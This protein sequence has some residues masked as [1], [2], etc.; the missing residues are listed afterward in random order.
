MK[1]NI[2]LL[3]ILI[4]LLTLTYFVHERGEE[5]QRRAYLERHQLFNPERLGSIVSFSN[6]NATVLKREGTYYVRDL[7]LEV[8]E[9]KMNE[10]FALLVPIQAKRFLED[11]ELEQMNL[12]IA[13]PHEHYTLTFTFENGRVEY[14]IGEKLK[15]GQDFYLRLRWQEGDR[16]EV[17]QYLIATD[18]SPSEGIYS[19]E[20]YHLSDRKYMRLLSLVFL[21][22]DFFVST[23]LIPDLKNT[24]VNSVSFDNR[25]NR[26]FRL[27]LAPELGIEP[28]PLAGV[29]VDWELVSAWLEDVKRLNAEKYLANYKVEDLPRRLALITLSLQNGEDV[30]LKLYRDPHDPLKYVVQSSHRK[31]LYRLQESASSLFLVGHQRFWDKVPSFDGALAFDLNLTSGETVTV[32]PLNDFHKRVG[33][34]G[35]EE[36]EL[37]LDVIGGLQARFQMPAQ[38]IRE[39]VTGDALRTLEVFQ[40]DKS[41]EIRLT[42]Q[43]I[44]LHDRELGL[45]YYYPQLGELVLPRSIADLTQSGLEQ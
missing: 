40:G 3:I 36:V 12:D 29:E 43:Y 14:L 23:R 4:S 8:D 17:T 6:V 39:E 45:V 22:E 10:A 32:L 25:N 16:E 24:Q 18:T 27:A 1:N 44:Q 21:E 2:G 15:F 33:R 13:F 34:S 9:E 19:Q 31:G 37:R 5:K 11:E 38:M 41:Y 26:A 7:G 30:E 42:E 28:T 20:T 35:G